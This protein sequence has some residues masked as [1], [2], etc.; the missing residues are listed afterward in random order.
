MPRSTIIY[1]LVLVVLSTF[2]QS[3]SL[4]SIVR[5]IRTG[6]NNL[7]SG[8]VDG[9]PQNDASVP[10]IP[11]QKIPTVVDRSIGGF[12]PDAYRKEMTELVYRRNLERGF[13]N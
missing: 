2:D 7:F 10:I 5:N 6:A 13:S 11:S 1:L 9:F 8:P 12:D 3:N 4:A